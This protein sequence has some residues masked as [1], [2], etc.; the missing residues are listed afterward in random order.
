LGALLR[1]YV[2]KE[3]RDW[4]EQLPYI[5]FAIRAYAIGTS[6]ISPFELLKG[7]AAPLPGDTWRAVIETHEDGP[8]W[9]EERGEEMRRL[10]LRFRDTQAGAHARASR[11]KNKKCSPHPA[12]ALKPG[13]KVARLVNNRSGKGLSATLMPGPYVP[14]YV[15]VEEHGD[16]RLTLRKTTGRRLYH[17]HQDD[18]RLE[19]RSR[20][21]QFIRDRGE[22]LLSLEAVG[23]TPVAAAQAGADAASGDTSADVG[24][25]P[26]DF[27]EVLTKGTLV[28]HN[29]ERQRPRWA[30]GTVWTTILPGASAV[31]VQAMDTQDPDRLNAKYER[32]WLVTV[33]GVS[34]VVL[35]DPEAHGSGPGSEVQPDTAMVPTSQILRAGF[36]L[37]GEQRLQS[38]ELNHLRLVGLTS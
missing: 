20:D 36:A 9:L 10:F 28:V 8:R 15:V 12:G 3:Q 7:M 38:A 21:G 30:V 4:D 35:G 19:R 16:G 18:V 23:S 29:T 1:V 27:E 25:E 22:Q 14:G 17:V 32:R 11:Y 24:D 5:A 2:S 31:E 33:N 26:D 13:T 6:G 37:T 34:R